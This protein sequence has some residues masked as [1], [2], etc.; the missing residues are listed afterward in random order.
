M[1]GTGG[2][3]PLTSR[4]LASAY[5]R[6][7]GVGILIDCGEATQI[8]MQKYGI[9]F[10]STDYILITH[11]HADH[12]SGMLGMMLAF[13]QAQ[14]TNP[15]TIVGPVGIKKYVET[16]L[17]ITSKFG[18]PV[19]FI[20][21]KKG[22]PNVQIKAGLN[23]EVI[24]RSTPAEH[25][26][27]CFAYSISLDRKP[28]FNVEKASADGI[29][30]YSLLDV[31]R[32]G[33]SFEYNGVYYDASIF[34]EAERQ[35]L[36]K[37]WANKKKVGEYTIV[38]GKEVFRND[39]SKDV[40]VYCINNFSIERNGM[41]YSRAEMN[42]VLLQELSQGKTFTFNGKTYNGRNYIEGARKGLKIS[43]VTDTRPMAHFRDF[44][45]GSDIA[46]IEGMYRDVEKKD[47]AISEKHMLWD[48]SVSLARDNNIG[49]VI[50]TH[51]SPSLQ[52]EP[53]DAN[54]LKS[55]LSNATLGRD[56][57][58]RHLKYDDEIV[59]PKEKVE[60]PI[61]EEKVV[62]P[63]KDKTKDANY[64]IEIV[65]KYYKRMSM[66]SMVEKIEPIT[67]F[68]YRVHMV[69]GVTHTVFVYKSIQS[70]KED[71]QNMLPVDD[72]FVF[73]Q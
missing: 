55:K 49:E 57:L 17:M 51:Y 4:A 48:E 68:K 36:A 3:Y 59:V 29:P 41:V 30:K 72:F 65:K 45:K 2:T 6:V 23:K 40:W 22:G 70:M 18:Y 31:F 64:R 50:L 1:L 15:V 54:L 67:S 43:Y 47:K 58:Y 62:K 60:S 32:K 10:N 25:S 34:S 33:H 19:N 5:V 37:G 27:P 52:I 63:Q 53:N 69:G 39:V 44:I 24:I 66:T 12:V 7:A 16:F 9:G 13:K 73:F 21:L 20:E 11:M 35:F 56:G 46:V 14:R 8:E 38:N 61:K 71:Y 42:V 28:R 26:R